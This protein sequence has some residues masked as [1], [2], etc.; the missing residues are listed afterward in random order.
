MNWSR[1][2]FIGAAHYRNWRF[3]DLRPGFLLTAACMLIAGVSGCAGQDESADNSIPGD[4]PTL[5][6][7]FALDDPPQVLVAVEAFLDQDNFYVS[8]EAGSELV[9]AGGNWGERIDL[10]AVRENSDGTYSGPYI[11]P[12]QYRLQ[13]RW[14]E[15]PDDPI[16]P[17]LLTVEQWERFRGQLFAAILPRDGRSGVAMHFDNDDYFLYYNRQG[18]FESR[19]LRD[20]PEDYSVQESLGFSEFMQRGLPQL[21]RF[22][23]AESIEGR[24]IVFSTGDTGAY[25]LP[26]LYV[27]LDLPVAVFVRQPAAQRNQA[28]LDAG[29]QAVQSAGHIAQSHLGGLAIRPVSSLFRLLFVASDSAIETVRPTWLA[30][31]E[32]QPIQNVSQASG[33]DLVEWEAELNRL[34]GRPA[35]RGTV[36]F[37]ID[38]EEYFTRLIDELTKA[39][40]SILIRTYI[41]D[42]DDFAEK[43]GQLLRRRS[44][45]GLEV[46]VLLDGLGTII[47]TGADDAGIPEDY[48]APAS[49]RVFL[50]QDSEIDVRQ[51]DNPWL[52]AGDHV[53]TTII[54]ETVVFTGGMNIGREYRYSWH[55]MMMEV[56]GPVVDLLLRDFRENWSLA[57]PTG[58][59][60]YFFQKIK[61]KRSRSD[62]VGDPL[63]I[64]YTNPGKPEIFRAQLAAIRNANSYIYIENAYFTDDAMLYEL[65]RARR[66]GVDVRVILPLVGNHGPINQSNVLAAN[67]MLEHGIRVFLYPGMSHMKIAVFDGWACLGSANWDKLSFRMNRELNLATA[68]PPAVEE[69]LQR[70]FEVDFAASL[71]LTEPFPA[72]WSDHLVEIFADYL[73]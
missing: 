71:E 69:L 35:S 9:Y 19:P 61:P 42:N 68:H 36:R 24:R 34:T 41:F 22:L 50:E 33:M 73:L 28:A 2:P 31:L 62:E 29:T 16:V 52:V 1:F 43:I 27:N 46:K 65:A 8:Y 55:D 67:A 60:G 37:L 3:A 48:V 49:V 18:S 30:T 15:N 13:T 44:N 6:G 32:S 10:E 66:R 21:A 56:R 72:R 38:G 54:D 11:L 63:R 45:D 51:V 4:Y 26:F 39:Q 70:V 58:D 25:S 57:G 14:P 17:E 12:L 59:L 20:K 40:D 7:S 47:A 23:E 53:K 5:P 64:L